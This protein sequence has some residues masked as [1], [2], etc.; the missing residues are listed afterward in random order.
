MVVVSTVS[1]TAANRPFVRY[2][3]N[4][5]VV[6][7]CDSLCFCELFYIFVDVCAWI[8]AVRDL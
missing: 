8:V 6:M 5:A 1:T 2:S 7:I 4:T 3:N